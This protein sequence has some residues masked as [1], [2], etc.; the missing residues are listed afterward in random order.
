MGGWVTKEE[1]ERERI[2]LGEERVWEA[3]ES[4][5]AGWRTGLKGGKSGMGRL[6]GGGA[7]ENAGPAQR[8]ALG[9]D[10]EG[11]EVPLRVSFGGELLSREKEGLR[12]CWGRCA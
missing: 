9:G 11:G 3:E 1:P 12:S 10:V 6:L 2:G 5:A 8:E 4:A 7:L